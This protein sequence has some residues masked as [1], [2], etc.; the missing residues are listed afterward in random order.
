MATAPRKR[1]RADQ[2]QGASSEDASGSA[3]A[4][5]QRATRMGPGD[6]PKHIGEVLAEV[7]GRLVLESAARRGRDGR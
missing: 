2:K 1:P 4:P 7:M 6:A 5:L 3:P